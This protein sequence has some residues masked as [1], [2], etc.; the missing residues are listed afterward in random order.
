L[1]FSLFFVTLWFKRF[2]AIL[3]AA[4]PLPTLQQLQPNNPPKTENAKLKLPKLLPNLPIFFEIE[5][6]EEFCE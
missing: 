1:Y 2:L 4:V 6:Y 3:A 5:E